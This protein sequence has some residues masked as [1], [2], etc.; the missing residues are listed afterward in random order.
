MYIVFSYVQIQGDEVFD[1]MEILEKA[2]AKFLSNRETPSSSKWASFLKSSDSPNLKKIVQ[3][4]FAVPTSNAFVERIFSIMKHLWSDSRNKLYRRMV[5][6]ELCIRLNFENSC[7][8]F[9]NEIKSNGKLI[10][11]AKSN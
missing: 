2:S 7:I 11:A 4:I 5:A 6:A 10:S 3:Y 9:Y 1:E 8:S